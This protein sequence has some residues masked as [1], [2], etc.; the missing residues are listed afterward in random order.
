MFNLSQGKCQENPYFEL[1]KKEKWQ[2]D[3]YYR[4]IWS[5]LLLHQWLEVIS[6]RPRGQSQTLKQ[7]FRGLLSAGHDFRYVPPS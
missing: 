4:G 2:A 3:Q 7:K 1:Q 6:Q 5:L